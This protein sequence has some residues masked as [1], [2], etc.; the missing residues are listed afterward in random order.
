MTLVPALGD[1][2]PIG[3]SAAVR[4]NG[5]IFFAIYSRPP[6][7]DDTAERAAI[8]WRKN[9]LGQGVASAK[10]LFILR[11]VTFERDFKLAW[12]HVAATA[13]TRAMEVGGG[14]VFGRA[15]GKA[16]D[17]D[18]PVFLGSPDA[19]DGQSVRAEDIAR[20]ERLPWSPDGFLILSGRRSFPG[21]WG[22]RHDAP[23]GTGDAH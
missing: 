13:R 1:P 11:A 21:E 12:A 4:A 8:A 9:L 10:D 14:Q 23:A 2:C 19:V 16:D 3:F 18:G 17:K 22:R 6:D 7:G 15:A 20:L 5:R